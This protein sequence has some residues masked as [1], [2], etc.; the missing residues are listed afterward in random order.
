MATETKVETKQVEEEKEVKICDYCRLI[1]S[2]DINDDEEFSE[3]MLNPDV[4][5]TD[6]NY[7]ATE[8]SVEEM[9][10]VETKEDVKEV[11]DELFTW[12]SKQ[13]VTLHTEN[14][15][16]LCPQCTDQLFGDEEPVGIRA[17]TGYL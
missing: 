7:F 16:D 17:G 2:E 14:T 13:Y 9:Q 8:S 4:D 10:D 1:T 15:A 6:P 11:V 12:F 5:V 3:M